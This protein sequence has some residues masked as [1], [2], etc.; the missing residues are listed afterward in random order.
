[1]AVY[2]GAKRKGWEVGAMRCGGSSH[3]SNGCL[4]LKQKKRGGIQASK[5]RRGA[6]KRAMERSHGI[7]VLILSR[8]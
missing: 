6:R 2:S 4:S 8:I 7:Q 3:E 1:L 5:E